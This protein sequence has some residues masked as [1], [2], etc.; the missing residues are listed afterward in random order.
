[1]VDA[2][3]DAV[4]SSVVASVVEL[5]GPALLDPS[6]PVSATLVSSPAGQA[7]T[8]TRNAHTLGIKARRRMSPA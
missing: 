2:V 8:A 5:V 4:V 6:V 3:V 1:M 7:M